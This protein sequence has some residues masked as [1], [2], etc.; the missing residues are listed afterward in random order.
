MGL[1]VYVSDFG[2]LK[3]PWLP[4]WWDM[5]AVVAFSLAVYFWA[6]SVALPVERIERMIDDGA[7]QDGPL[8]AYG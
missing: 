3:H 2:P 8:T 7:A 1:V 4:L 6:L 5:L